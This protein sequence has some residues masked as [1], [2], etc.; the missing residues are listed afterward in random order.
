[1]GT[2]EIYKENTMGKPLKEIY[3]EQRDLRDKMFLF[4]LMACI[5]LVI[6]CAAIMLLEG[7]SL[8]TVIFNAG[9][10]FVMLMLFRLAFIKGRRA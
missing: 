6:T 7:N 10:A 8:W 2:A 1:M 9:A 5:V 4:S 3:N